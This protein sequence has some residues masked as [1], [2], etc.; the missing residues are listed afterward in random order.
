[1]ADLLHRVKE[2]LRVST[3]HCTA[4]A[5]APA[6]RS[7]RA[8]PP[9]GP[10]PPRRR[11]A[12]AG[13]PRSVPDDRAPC[14]TAEHS[15]PPLAAHHRRAPCASAGRGRRQAARRHRAAPPPTSPRAASKAAVRSSAVS[16][17]RARARLRLSRRSNAA[18]TAASI[19]AR[20]LRACSSLPRR[21]GSLSGPTPVGP[22]PPDTCAKAASVAS[23]AGHAAATRAA[24]HADAPAAREPCCRLPD[25]HARSKAK[26][27]PTRS[28]L[29]GR[30]AVPA[31]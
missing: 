12:A 31:G 16:G 19:C 11:A 22:L 17:A 29:G 18:A 4:S 8:S 21:H 6:R 26:G 23:H 28:S 25:G 30:G 14:D 13:A 20:H 15:C 1:M 5:R 9:L 10:A 27:A 3:P 7:V 24:A 2:Q